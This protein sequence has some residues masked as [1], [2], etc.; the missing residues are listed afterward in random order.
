MEVLS[1]GN[2]NHQHLP[3]RNPQLRRMVVV[4][5]LLE[6]HNLENLSHQL[7]G[8]LVVNNL[9]TMNLLLANH[10]LRIIT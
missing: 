2:L 10:L 9:N 5:K 7:E 8:R 4:T 1:K 3:H 6:E